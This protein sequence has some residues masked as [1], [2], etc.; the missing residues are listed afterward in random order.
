MRFQR[1]YAEN[2]SLFREFAVRPPYKSINDIFCLRANRM[3]NPYRKVSINKFE[4]KVPEAPLHDL[5]ACGN[6]QAESIQ[7]RIVPD[8]ESGLSEVRFWY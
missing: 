4:L 6:A 3:V 2:K 8:R 5:S 1:A 7:L